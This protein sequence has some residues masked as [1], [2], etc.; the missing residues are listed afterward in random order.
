[1]FMLYTQLS[2]T[3]F[4]LTPYWTYKK[5]IQLFNPVDWNHP[6]L[7]NSTRV[8]QNGVIPTN[9]ASLPATPAL[10]PTIVE[11]ATPNGYIG[12]NGYVKT[13]GYPMSNGYALPNGHTMSNGHAMS[14]G[15]AKSGKSNG[16]TKS[17][18]KRK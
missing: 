10:T 6:E 4:V 13:D 2:I 1:M 5:M 11:K 18:R 8:V 3:F 9:K 12:T 17:A 15:Y 14:N 16:K 7:A